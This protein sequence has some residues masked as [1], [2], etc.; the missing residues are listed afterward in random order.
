MEKHERVNLLMEARSLIN[1]ATRKIRLALEGTS[2]ER[3]AEVYII[4]HLLNWAN[5]E[6]SMDDTIPK[7]IDEI[8][9]E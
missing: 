5:G 2:G 6:N 4:G 1:D 3:S 7:L 9:E 8:E